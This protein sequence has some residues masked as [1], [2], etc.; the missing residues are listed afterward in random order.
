[1]N[2]ELKHVP[3]PP[4][5]PTEFPHILIAPLASGVYEIL[6]PGM[7][8]GMSLPK[9][10]VSGLEETAKPRQFIVGESSE[11]HGPEHHSMER[12][13]VDR[14]LKNCGQLLYG[15]IDPD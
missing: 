6:T 4:P 1:M 9:Q 8:V 5:P 10:A 15:S 11:N 7:H 13:D 12:W 2:S 14:F 3:P